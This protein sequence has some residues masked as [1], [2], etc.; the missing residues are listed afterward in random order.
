MMNWEFQ[1]AQVG[2]TLRAEAAMKELYKKP[3]IV[4]NILLVAAFVDMWVPEQ[5]HV[6]ERPVTSALVIAIAAL[7]ASALISMVVL[8]RRMLSGSEDILRTKPDDRVAGKKWFL[9]HLVTMVCCLAVVL[10]GVILRFLG[11]GKAVAFSFYGVGIAAM[12]V[13]K[14]RRIG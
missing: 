4:F 14:P 1:A 9:G 8:R 3:E 13:F 5:I 2:A 6:H 11:A 10:Y 12:I 7:A